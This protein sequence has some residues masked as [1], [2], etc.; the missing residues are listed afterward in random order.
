[1][2]EP[3]QPPQTIPRRNLILLAVFAI[4]ALVVGYFGGQTVERGRSDSPQTKLQLA[5]QA[6]RSGYDQA[7][8]SMLTPLADEGN[9]K[10]QYWLADIYENGLGVKQDMKGALV[11]LQKSAALGFVPA[12]RHLGELYLQGNETLQDFGQAQTWLHKAAIAGDGIAQRQL[13]HIFALGLGVT[14]D[15]PQAYGWY[16][17]A[18]LSG[19]GLARPMRED[20]LSRMSPTDVAKAEQIAKHTANEIKP[21]KP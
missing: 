20:I 17:N 8:L 13:G 10:A 12:E 4:A 19:D 9:A 18:V 14:R 7:A 1:M 3:V 21:A 2:Q 16:E 11:L 6:F 15:L 5:L